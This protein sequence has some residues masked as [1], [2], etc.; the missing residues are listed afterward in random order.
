MAYTFNCEIIHLEFLEEDARE[1][2]CGRI[3]GT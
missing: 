3:L 1:G 2:V